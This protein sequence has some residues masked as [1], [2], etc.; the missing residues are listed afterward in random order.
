M[1]V[2]TQHHTPPSTTAAR[3]L[4]TIRSAHHVRDVPRP[5]SR[6]QLCAAAA[7]RAGRRGA[8]ACIISQGAPQ[9]DSVVSADGQPTSHATSL[10][11]ASVGGA[12]A[13][14]AIT[15]IV[16]TIPA[17]IPRAALQQRW[18]GPLR[19]LNQ[20]A[21]AGL[22][23]ECRP[24]L[25]GTCLGSNC[26]LHVHFATE[27]LAGHLAAGRAVCVCVCAAAVLLL[28]LLMRA[29]LDPQ[30]TVANTDSG[31][32]SVAPPLNRVSVGAQQIG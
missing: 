5:K 29:Q 17:T 27:S 9:C 11:F 31:G 20:L 13:V 18:H 6:G 8:G 14:A 1:V 22:A 3:N 16:A 15:T 4:T 30:H 19:P 26:R 23:F 12:V 10:S 32:H 7:A 2:C 24:D 28:C 25:V 21:E